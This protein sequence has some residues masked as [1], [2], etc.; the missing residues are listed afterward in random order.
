M[1]VRLSGAD[2]AVRALDPWPSCHQVL[3]GIADELA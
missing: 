1:R 3:L 2:I